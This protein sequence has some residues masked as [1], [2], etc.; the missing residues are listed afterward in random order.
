MFALLTLLAQDQPQGP[1]GWA[2]LVPWLII[3]PILYLLLIRP[4][5][6]QAREQSN[7]L[8]SLQKGDKVVTTAGIIG[9]LDQT[10]KPEDTEVV[11][12]V[13]R[14]N[15]NVR[16]QVLKSSLSGKLGDAKPSGDK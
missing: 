11:L 12:R 16:I 6:V 14:N 5:Q 1:P 2:A 15:S 3:L 9:W 10:P 13:D 4:A 7:M 8:A